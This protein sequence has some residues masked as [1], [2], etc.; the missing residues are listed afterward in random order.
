MKTN[1]ETD[2]LKIKVL[3]TEGCANTPLAI[4]RIEEVA[5]ELGIPIYIEKLRIKTQEEAIRNRFFGSPT[6]QIN[7]V[8]ID[9]EKKESTAYGI[10]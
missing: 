10:G 3:S 8:D 6:I 5:K 2:V 9:P 1:P 7:G 4:S